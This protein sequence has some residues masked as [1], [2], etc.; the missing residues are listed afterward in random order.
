[1]EILNRL[2]TEAAALPE[3]VLLVAAPALLVVA[4]FLLAVFHADR[5]YAPVA[6]GIGGAGLFLFSCIADALAEY[7]AWCGL[8][9]ALCA[10]VRLFFLIPFPRRKKERRNRDEEIYEK[11]RLELEP[12]PPV[13]EKEDGAQDAVLNA[14][15][16]GLRLQH[17]DEMIAGLLAAELEPG[18]RL[19]TDAVCRT[20]DL[21][22]NKSLTEEELRSLNDCLATVL[23]LS[24]KYNL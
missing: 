1:M 12:E 5:A 9:L 10:I 18:D 20:L 2:M 24:A 6:A 17:A 13:E 19:E 21:Y 22:R 4:G 3:Y 15:E 14:E 7:A 8:Y 11:F 23:R 16:C